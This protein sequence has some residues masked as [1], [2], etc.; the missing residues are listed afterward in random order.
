MKNTSKVLFL[1]REL[2]GY[3]LGSIDAALEQF[4]DLEIKIVY[5]PANDEAPFELNSDI[6]R[7]EM[8]PYRTFGNK[9]MHSLLNEWNPHLWVVAGWS[10]RRYM[11]WVK[12][13]DHYFK[14]IAFDTQWKESFKFK[15][16]VLWL[17]YKS[18]RFFNGV[19]VPGIRQRKLAE[20]L[21]FKRDY[22]KLGYYVAQEM[23]SHRK[24]SRVVGDDEVFK[25]VFVN[26]LVKQKGFPDALIYLNRYIERT[27]SNWKVYVIGTGKLASSCPKSEWIEYVGFVQPEHLAQHLSDKDVYVLSS[28]YE[29]WGVSVHEAAM[30]G[31]PM[32]LSSA[33]GAGD[34]F[35]EPGRNGFEFHVNDYKGMVRYIRRIYRMGAEA[36]KDWGLCS[37]EF[38]RRVNNEQWGRNLM[39]WVKEGKKCAE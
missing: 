15:V 37:E 26:R 22:I 17:Y 32:V 8:I 21:F 4:P 9:E 33:V 3:F 16:G 7:L 18:I 25:I 35:L 11:K 19:W 23:Q 5:W 36:R 2:S 1:V 29:P 27:H 14:V 24:D 12:Q 39:D 34:T 30:C 10:D 6:E 13:Y 20:K 28:N 31:L 38:S